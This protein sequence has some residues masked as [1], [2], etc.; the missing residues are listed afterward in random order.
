[1]GSEADA[2]HEG[3]AAAAEHKEC[4]H[5]GAGLEGSKHGQGK[6]GLVSSTHASSQ[7]KKVGGSKDEA[8]LALC[9]VKL[10]GTWHWGM[11]YSSLWQLGVSTAM[12]YINPWMGM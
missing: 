9:L 5:K 1:M 12:L 6:C 3:V 2:W 4:M 11:S 8:G 10:V 7:G